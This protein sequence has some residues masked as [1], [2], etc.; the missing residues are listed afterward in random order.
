MTESSTDSTSVQWSNTLKK[1][2]YMNLEALRSIRDTFERL[3]ENDTTEL[4][5]ATWA[6]ADASK[7]GEPTLT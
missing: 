5:A 1:C 2:D 3:W 4:V 6:I 7:D